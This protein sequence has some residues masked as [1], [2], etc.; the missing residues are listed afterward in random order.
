MAEVLTQEEIDQLLT[1]ITGEI[2]DQPPLLAG[3]RFDAAAFLEGLAARSLQP[4]PRVGMFTKEVPVLSFRTTPNAEEVLADIRALNRAQGGGTITVPG[5]KLELVN[6]S[7]C[8]RCNRLFSLND[9]RDYYANPVPDSALG[10]IVRQR[11]VDTRM[12]CGDCGCQF[13]PSL[14]VADGLPRNEV[15]FL[16][17]LQTIHAVE[18]WMRAE[19]GQVVLSRYPA[20]LTERDGERVILNDLDIAK[21]QPRPGLILNIL[22]YSTPPAM[23]N[24]LDGRNRAVGDPIYGRAAS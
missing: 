20:N 19:H 13:L 18:D 24:F 12:R 17:R 9:L 21:L 14:V 3:G 2:D 15:Q 22:Q 16:C 1:P 8:P 4:E 23:L 11:L 6:F 7:R 5:T 10:G